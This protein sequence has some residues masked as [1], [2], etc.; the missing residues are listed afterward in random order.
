MG[1]SIIIKVS[2]AEHT[3]NAIEDIVDKSHYGHNNGFTNE[4]CKRCV[5]DETWY[6]WQPQ[7][8]TWFTLSIWR[9]AET[10]LH[11]SVLLPFSINLFLHCFATYFYHQKS[12]CE[13]TNDNRLDW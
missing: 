3:T 9:C 5:E 1:G 10:H 7:G 12:H 4:M 11:V 13:L 6:S 8:D 2:S